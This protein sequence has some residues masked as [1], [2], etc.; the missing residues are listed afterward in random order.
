VVSKSLQKR[1]RGWIPKEPILPT[2][3][4]SNQTKHRR[5][6]VVF[7]NLL[8]GFIVVAGLVCSVLLSNSW[9][10]A[11]FIVASVVIAFLWLISR[12]KIKN[13]LKF[14]LTVVMIFSI[15][16]TAVEGH[17]FWNSG[18]PATYLQSQPTVS[19]TMQT[20]LNTS[21]LQIVQ[22]I[23][24]SPTFGLL[25]LE[26]GENITLQSIQLEPD[27]RGY[28]C[29]RVDFASENSNTNF[30]FYSSNGHQFIV[31]VLNRQGQPMSQQ[32]PSNSNTTIEQALSQIDHLGLNWFYNQALDAAQNRT[33]NL[34]TIDNLTVDLTFGQG[35]G[36]YQGITLRLIGYHQVVQLNSLVNSDGVLISEFEPNG[37]L[38]YMSKPVQN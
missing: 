3:A 13:A 22:E 27:S 19:L 35:T 37:A 34:P 9:I 17:L 29:I 28:S 5:V 20:M 2:N 31:Q 11:S 16:F 4:V 6:G 18:Y 10:K 36:T 32:Y 38:I 1:I 15:A 8:V 26:H 24:Q 7:Q 33:T 21:L 23:E 30:H 14:T 25:K 12:G